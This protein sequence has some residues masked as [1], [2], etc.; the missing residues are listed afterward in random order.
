LIHSSE[1][2]ERD[3]ATLGERNELTARPR[4]ETVVR[5]AADIAERHAPAYVVVNDRLEIVHF[6]GCTGRFLDPTAGAATLSLLDFVHR[7]LRLILRA[8]LHGV[9]AEGRPTKLTRVPMAGDGAATAGTI[10]IEPIQDAGEDASHLVVLFEEE[11]AASESQMA[12]ERLRAVT[13]AEKTLRESEERFRMIA[14]TVPDIMFTSRPDGHCEFMNPRFYQY[15][16]MQEGSAL[17]EGWKRAIHSEDLDKSDQAWRNAIEA[18]DHFEMVFRLRGADGSYRW[19][20]CRAEPVRSGKGEVALWLGSSSDIHEF[21]MAND[22]QRMLVAELQHRVKNILAV[23]RS[24]FTRSMEAAG[25]TEAGA[26]HFRGR[27]D[28]LARTQNVLARTPEGGIDLE[29]MIQNE[30]TCHGTL[31]GEQ[32]QIAGPA[33]RLRQK[34]AEALGLAIHELATNAAKYG[35]LT[36]GSGRIGVTWRLYHSDTGPRLSWKWVESGVNLIDPAPSRVGFGRELIEHGLP[37][38]LGAMT[39]LEF[40]S[41]GI[42]C[43]I[44]LPLSE[45]IAVLSDGDLEWS[46]P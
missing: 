29:E 23:I 13:E 33:I 21:R 45:R 25:A 41:G 34:A 32:V 43:A 2:P 20:R 35:A 37:Y 11:D 4:L 42:N 18:G 28:A 44:E 14:Q 24:I 6:S 17:G 15:T 1:Q 7:D 10:I 38:Q 3:E 9:L 22:R 27:L 30:L 16:G 19:F 39:A 31:N 5:R 46:R 26:D 40:A 12:D 8:A 36:T